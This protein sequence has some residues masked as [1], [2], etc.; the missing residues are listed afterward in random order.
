[1]QLRKKG[2]RVVIGE[3][4]E[5]GTIEKEGRILGEIIA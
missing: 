4:G 1:L 5:E 2:F 3:E